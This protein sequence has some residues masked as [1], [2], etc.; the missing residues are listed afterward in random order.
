M[1]LAQVLGRRLGSDDRGKRLAEK[2]EEGVL[3]WARKKTA[4]G[5][6]VPTTLVGERVEL[7]LEV[8]V[9]LKEL[10]NEREIAALLRVTPGTARRLSNELLSM[11]ED[12]VQPFIF[13][14][15]LDGARD[16]GPGEYQGVKGRRVS[17]SSTEKL[18][19]FQVEAKRSALP[20]AR[21]RGEAEHPA[22][23]YVP[24]SFA[25]SEYGLQ[26]DGR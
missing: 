12:T 26:R 7:L 10:L 6:A 24:N 16:L 23:L 25:F 11:Y 1:N 21:K 5:G 20:V 22:L 15:A 2:Y 18:E 4:G 9:A 3:A 8:S 14:Y 13:R 17:F 19:V